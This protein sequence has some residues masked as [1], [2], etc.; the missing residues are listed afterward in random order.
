M[1]FRHGKDTWVGVGAYDLTP[2]LNSATA[3]GTVETAET[4][5]FGTSAKTYIPGRADG[6]FQFNGLFDWDPLLLENK[7]QAIQ[8]D[9][10]GV[11]VTLAQDGGA[12]VGRRAVGGRAINTQ[13]QI[14]AQ[15]SDVVKT[16]INLQAVGGSRQGWV[17]SDAVSHSTTTTFASVDGIAASTAGV[18]AYVHVLANSSASNTIKVQHSTD[19]TTFVDVATATSMST[20]PNYYVITTTGTLNRYLRAVLTISTGSAT[21][22]VSAYRN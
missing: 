16:S 21:A 8:A 13:W 3:P 18:T 11:P 22:V 12:V 7:L 20:T 14:D 1:V 6:T 10:A 17:L 19:G 4:S 15:I 9:T 2:W 5:H